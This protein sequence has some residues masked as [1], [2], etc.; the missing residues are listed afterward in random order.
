MQYQKPIILSFVAGVLNYF[1]NK[2]KK[3]EDW[4]RNSSN[5]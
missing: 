5:I 2:I 3:D 4:V 1:F